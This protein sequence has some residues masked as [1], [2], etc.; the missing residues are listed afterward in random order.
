MLFALLGNDGSQ[1]FSAVV[2]QIG[3]FVGKKFK[4]PE[5]KLYVKLDTLPVF[6][7]EWVHSCLALN[8]LSGL[9]QWVARGQ[10]VDN[11]TFAEITESKNIPKDLTGKLILGVVFNTFDQKWLQKSNKVTN[12]NLLLC[13]SC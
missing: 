11:S 7:N 2:R 5:A 8:T 12:L 3:D 1:W 9:V 4:Y 10:L 6:P 13:S